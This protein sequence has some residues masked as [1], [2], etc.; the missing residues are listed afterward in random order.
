M[1]IHRYTCIH[2]ALHAYMY[3]Y[4]YIYLYMY[5][6]MYVY[7]YMYMDMY[8]Y[9]YLYMSMYVYVYMYRYTYPYMYTYIVHMYIC[10][11]TWNYSIVVMKNT[12]FHAVLGTYYG[13]NVDGFSTFVTPNPHWSRSTSWSFWWVLWM[14]DFLQEI[15]HS[16]TERGGFSSQAAFSSSSVF[17]VGDFSV[18]VPEGGTN[19]RSLLR[20]VWKL[21]IWQWKHTN[22]LQKMCRRICW[23]HRSVGRK[24][25]N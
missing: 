12:I 24:K 10:H 23:A 21:W 22:P 4:M 16:H 1:Y 20:G 7:L 15:P 18:P 9:L 8:M 3:I 11:I 13:C 25:S 19:G 6:C 14:F 17:S 5:M 2:A